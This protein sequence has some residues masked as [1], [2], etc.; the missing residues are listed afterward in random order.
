MFLLLLQRVL[1][2]SLV[3]GIV[4]LL[5]IFD[6]IENF[7]PTLFCVDDLSDQLARLSG[8]QGR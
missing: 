1:A 5:T 3:G 2:V 7:R 6:E 8:R 4:S